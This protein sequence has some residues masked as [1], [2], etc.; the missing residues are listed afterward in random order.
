TIAPGDFDNDG[1]IDYIVGNTGLNSFY[2]ASEKYPV[3]VYGKD[4]NND[5]SY[6][7]VTS[8]YLPDKNH[9]ATVKEFPAASRD[10]LIRQ[11]IS[12][13]RRYENYVSYANSTMDSVIPADQRQDAVIKHANNFASCYV[14]NDGSGK[15]SLQR[16]PVNAQLSTLCGI[17]VSDFD[18]DGNLD[19]VING[20]D[21]GT[22][23]GTGRY[24]ALNG[25]MMKGDGSGGFTALTIMQSGI[26][27][28]G[29]GKSLVQ[30]RSSDKSYLLAAA[31]NRGP[32]RIFKLKRDVNMLPAEAGEVGA[33]VFLKN[34]KKRKQ[35]IY[36]GASYLSQ[37]SRFV[38]IDGNVKSVQFYNSTGATRTINF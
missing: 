34:G 22:E 27:I 18:G 28:P 31:E 36:Y 11:M 30:L 19:V 21:Y 14:R 20:N 6:D 33:I 23:V 37:S 8:L 9:N 32:L 2:R 25:L 35:E 10:E 24:D 16:L 38:A 26:F 5:G 12:M 13:R 3:S 1:D 4:F 29:N 15:F 17:A 7:A